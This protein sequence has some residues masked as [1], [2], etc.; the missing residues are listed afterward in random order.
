MEKRLTVYTELKIIHSLFNIDDFGRNLHS[1][2]IGR[3]LKTKFQ[4]KKKKNSCRRFELTTFRVQAQIATIVLR[5]LY[6]FNEKKII[7]T[8]SNI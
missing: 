2:L 7:M 8:I 3:Y 1:N 5:Y 6:D 4:K